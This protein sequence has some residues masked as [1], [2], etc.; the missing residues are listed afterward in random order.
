VPDTWTQGILRQEQQLR[1]Q[2]FRRE[3]ARAWACFAVAAALLFLV[4]VL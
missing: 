1:H 4:I 2:R 3:L